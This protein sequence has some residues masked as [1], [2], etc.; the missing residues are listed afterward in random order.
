M[1]T[2]NNIA[3]ALSL[4]ER[5]VEAIEKIVVNQDRLA[6]VTEKNLEIIQDNMKRQTAAIEDMKAKLEED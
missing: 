2:S 4:A 1:I 5:F 6:D 3:R